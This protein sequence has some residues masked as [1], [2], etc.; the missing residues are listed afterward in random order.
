M[1]SLKSL[2][3][4]LFLSYVTLVVAMALSAIAAF[5][6]IAGLMA[7]FAAAVIP[8]AIMGS[9]LEMAK[10]TVTLW[11]HEYWRDAKWL[12][13]GYLCT[14]V[15]ILMMI[16]S[17]GIFGFLSKAHLDQA[18]PTGAV[19]DQVAMID[20]KI[21]T[22]QDN[23][24][25]ARRALAQMDSQV[26]QMLGRTT[27][28]R[29][30]ERSNQIRKNQAR[31]RGTLQNDISKAQKE[32]ARLKEER[33][34][35][36]KELRKVEAEVGP[37]KYIAA[38]IYN[39]KPDETMLEKAVRWVIISIVLVFDPLAI[40]MLLAATESM[41]WIKR[42]RREH[43]P[44]PVQAE[45]FGTLPPDEDEEIIPE[46]LVAI[47]QKGQ[48]QTEEEKPWPFPVVRPVEGNAKVTDDD[49]AAMSI[50]PPEEIPGIVTRPWTDEEISAFDQ[51]YDMSQEEPK[52]DVEPNAIV[53][54]KE[55][56][57]EEEKE[58]M[59]LW[60]VQHPETTIKEQRRLL[61]Q[62]KIDQLPW[63]HN[64]G[65]Q[66]D[67]EPLSGN[68]SGFGV[69][70]PAQASKGDMFLRVDM[71]PTQLYKFNGKKW[72]EVDKDLNDSYTYD[73]AYIDYLIAK[74]ES[75]EYD[76]ELLTYTEREEIA[77]RLT[78]QKSTGA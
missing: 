46:A 72:I 8:I 43:P 3:K 64:V 20:E 42:E 73:A 21:K 9:I 76:P 6:S 71:L 63:Q 54:N 52:V 62:G 56:E 75:G 7:I 22:Q 57:P 77:H 58:A 1:Y 74:L 66:A 36:A 37:I 55:I 4:S 44:A 16:T 69:E 31:E 5:Y 38:L 48:T 15:V 39:D 14:A 59:R 2:N 68:V 49:Q 29:G 78:Q 70:W 25:S 27:D 32:I 65:L 40:M 41:G 10:V 53:E 50:L 61:D 24:D 45:D 51:A 60:K 67:N 18:V 26:D 12:M 13:K 17:M 19:A 35:I 28:D 34:P 30:A 11:L 33:A 23:V 47:F